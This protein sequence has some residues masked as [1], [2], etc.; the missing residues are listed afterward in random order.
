MT[1]AEA[2]KAIVGSHLAARIA[3]GACVGVGTGSTVDLAIM[4]LGKR[5]KEEG[6]RVTVVPTSVA[7]AQRCVEVGLLVASPLAF[8]FPLSLYFDGADEVDPNLRLIKGRGGALLQE[9]IIAVSSLEFIV[10]IDP[11]KLVDR[12]GA[13]CAI[14]IE[15]IPS[16]LPYV[17]NKLYEL[18][19]SSLELR[20]GNKS[21]HGPIITENGNFIVDASFPEV[22]LSLEAEL[23]CIVGVVEHGVFSGLATEILIAEHGGVRSIK[24]SCE[25]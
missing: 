17:K 15:I 1:L 24:K 8:S 12:L 22:S 20:Q 25:K 11:I 16:S 21:K 7:T 18:G 4:A 2:N 23:K 10:L 19:A 13:R 3:D 14:P 6:L 9:K 5:V